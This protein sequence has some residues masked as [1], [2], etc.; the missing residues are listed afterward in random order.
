M[1]LLVDEAEAKEQ[2]FQQ[3]AQVETAKAAV[4]GKFPA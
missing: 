4:E 2:A 3:K 1:K